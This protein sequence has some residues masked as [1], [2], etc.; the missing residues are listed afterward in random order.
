MIGALAWLMG[1]QTGRT[2][3][4][5]SLAA[6]TVAAIFWRA[7]SAGQNAERAAQTQAALEALRNRI[8]SDDAIEKMDAGARRR[9]LRRW[10]SNDSA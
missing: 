5:I 3:A 6:L 7:F 2:I 8:K 4:A 10:L 1:S 9:E